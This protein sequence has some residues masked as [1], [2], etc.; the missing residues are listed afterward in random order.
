M[1]YNAEVTVL[2]NVN[3]DNLNESSKVKLSSVKKDDK[4]KIAIMNEIKTKKAI[5]NS[6]SSIFDCETNK[7]RLK[8]LIGL[9]S[10]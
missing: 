9:T 7:L 2:V 10:R 8:I 6:S 1:P 5:F 4:T 3:I